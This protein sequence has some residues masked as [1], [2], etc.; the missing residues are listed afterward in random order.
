VVV[1]I[2]THL[3]F[4]RPLGYFS[5][6]AGVV[7]GHEFLKNFL[8]KKVFTPVFKKTAPNPHPQSRSTSHLPGYAT[9]LA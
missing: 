8:K 3:L 5:G 4:L 6:V 1:R 2:L 7:S 9:A